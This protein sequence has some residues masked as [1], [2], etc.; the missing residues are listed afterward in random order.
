MVELVE[1]VVGVRWVDVDLVLAIRGDS[2]QD[3]IENYYRLV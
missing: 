2:I 3:E 1:R